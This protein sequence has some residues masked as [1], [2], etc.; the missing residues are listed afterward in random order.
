VHVVACK[1]ELSVKEVAELYVDRVFVLHGLSREFITD[2]DTR[3][4][5]AFQW[6]KVTILLS[7][8]TVMFFSFHPQTNGQTK[9]VYKSLGTYLRHFVSVGLND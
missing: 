4:T 9:R 6:Q 3:F 8:E 7:T 2:R 1:E 5:S